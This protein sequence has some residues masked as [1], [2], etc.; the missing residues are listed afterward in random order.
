MIAGGNQTDSDDDIRYIS[1]E[2]LRTIHDKDEIEKFMKKLEIRIAHHDQE[3]EKMCSAHYKSFIDS[4]QEL[5]QVRPN[6]DSLKRETTEIN[7]ELIKSTETIQ[8]KAEELI[9]A[10]RILV[11]SSLSIELIKKCLFVLEQY[12]TFNHQ[13]QEKKYFPAL[14]TLE[15]LERDHLPTVA[16]YRF[17]Q[18]MCKEIP[19]FRD[20]IK[21]ASTKD[22]N[23]FLEG[24]LM[25]SQKVGEIVLRNSKG[26]SGE[27][28]A[29]SLVDFCPVYRGLHI[30][31]NLGFRDQFDE[32][33]REQRQK[34]SRLA[35]SPPINMSQS[36]SS[37][38]D[39][40]SSIVG[41]FVIEDHLM[42]TTKNFIQPDYLK[43]LW[44]N[45]M[46]SMTV[47]LKRHAKL[48]K[49]TSMMLKIKELIMLFTFTIRNYGHGTEPLAEILITIREQYNEILMNQWKCRFE[50]IFQQD[51]Y[52]PL[53]VNNSEEYLQA[54]GALSFH[55]TD[56][57]SFPKK[58]PFSLF[59]PKVYEEVRS[60]I[61][62]S[63]K[64]SQDLNSSQA[65][66]ENMVR[67]STNQLLTQTLGS[68][69][70][71]LINDSSLKLLQLIQI[72][73][74]TNYLEEAMQF[75]DDHITYQTSKS[76]S[77]LSSC[78]SLNP[79]DK[80]DCL[81]NPVFS[82]NQ[83]GAKQADTVNSKVVARSVSQNQ[84]NM[85][86]DNN[87]NSLGG[88]Q[89]KL[90][91]KSMFKDARADA[92]SQIYRKLNDQ[93]DEFLSLADYD[94]TLTEANGQ[95]SSFIS[96]LIA[97]LKST[98]QA[99]TNLP[100]RIAQ[101]ACM[102]ACKHIAQSLRDMLLSD[103]VK[104][105]SLG[106]L[107]QFNL[108]LMQCEVFAGSEPVKGFKEGDL[109]MA[110]AELRQ[111]CDLFLYEDYSTYMSDMGKQQNKYLRVTTV[112]ALSVVDKLR[113]YDRKKSFIALKRNDKQKLRD[114]FAKNLRQ[115]QQQQSLQNQQ[116][117]QQ[118]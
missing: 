112:T 109:Q 54:V 60:F 17:A 8:R 27:T 80:L 5:L 65:D 9:K 58:F 29:L 82:I 69:L 45:A 37:Y 110:F 64:F 67:K 104:A 18:N 7:A 32:Y 51:N 97:W 62:Q 16:N 98:F 111:L 118:N 88:N 108:D 95:A 12:S 14:K 100:E 2:V 30:F 56:T 74:N 113:E 28:S 78:Y 33:Y 38:H 23:D 10:R 48:C 4:I 63:L 94:W 71:T 52:H 57:S 26:I 31:T 92:E 50:E 85:L 43:G 84:L 55:E 90:Q 53:E 61:E 81:N 105:L 24:L 34:Q 70:T 83:T 36:I 20:I 6:A 42:G 1:N 115:V 73:I 66:V 47:A 46:Q 116:A 107:E 22:L 19:K 93:I 117:Q 72:T 114:T 77:G 3:I 11:N 35:F 75:L 102:S 21:E 41:F 87:S 39:Y 59:V 79:D 103:D 86:V 13:L 99:F 40:F 49:D 44:Q 76:M 25:K 106:S 15:S 89:I 91:G 96:D 101:G 68:C